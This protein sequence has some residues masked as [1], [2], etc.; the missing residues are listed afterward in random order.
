MIRIRASLKPISV[1][2]FKLENFHLLFLSL[3]LSKKMIY[4]IF[5]FFVIATKIVNFSFWDVC[6]VGET[7]L[8]VLKDQWVLLLSYLLADKAN[9]SSANCANLSVSR[10]FY[11]FYLQ[12]RI[13]VIRAVATFPSCTLTTK[14]SKMCSF[15]EDIMPQCQT[16]NDW[17]RHF[18]LYFS[19]K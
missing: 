5:K 17:T 7:G 14:R 2:L 1:V 8:G 11:L 18:K 15:L 12:L 3:T 9:L 16:K 10:L 13:H 19:S 4:W 6:L